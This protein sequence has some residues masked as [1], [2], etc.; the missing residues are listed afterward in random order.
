MKKLFIFILLVFSINVN[1][2]R[3]DKPGEPYKAY[4][5]LRMCESVRCEITLPGKEAEY[6]VDEENK[7]IV[8]KNMITAITYM[9][10]RGWNFSF[11]YEGY[12]CAMEKMVRSDEELLENISTSKTPSKTKKEKAK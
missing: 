7:P 10:K 12:I 11:V 4:C 5:F 3:I 8:F 9:S 2:Q 6:L 1:A